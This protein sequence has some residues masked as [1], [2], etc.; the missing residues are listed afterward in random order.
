MM[1]LEVHVKS[2]IITHK[3]QVKGDLEIGCAEPI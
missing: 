2:V 3:V 1:G